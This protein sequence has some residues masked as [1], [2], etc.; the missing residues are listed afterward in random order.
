V[1][2]TL[3]L[4]TGAGLLGRSMLRVLAIDP[5][6]D[7]ERIVMVDLRLPDVEHGDELRRVQFLEQLTT[8]IQALPGVE[9]VGGTN[10]FPLKNPDSADGT[11]VVI[12]PQQL[13]PAQRG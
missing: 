8:G 7:A 10:V 3:T 5:G 11:F 4:L 6:F 12:N 1:A 9:A 2:I 13:T